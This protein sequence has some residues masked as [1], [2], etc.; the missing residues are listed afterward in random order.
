MREPSPDTVV[1][2]CHGCSRQVVVPA[3]RVRAALRDRRAY[4]VFCTRRCNMTYVATEG[5]R[6]Q[7]AQFKDA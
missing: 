1:I 7:E 3:G 4:V 5:A 2:P 6:Q